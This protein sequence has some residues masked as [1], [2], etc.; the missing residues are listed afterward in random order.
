MPSKKL[1]GIKMSTIVWIALGVLA[2]S[3]IVYSSAK[4]SKVDFYTVKQVDV[5]YT[6]LA[7]CSVEYPDPLDL[8][9][10]SEG[11]VKSIL[12]REGDTVVNGQAIL[13][14]DD[15]DEQQNLII[16]SNNLATSENKLKS[17]RETDLPKLKEQLTQNSLALDQAKKNLERIKSLEDIGGVSK[18]EI[19]SAQNN[20]D[21]L[22]AQYNQTKLTIDTYSSTGPL[23]DLSRQIIV[24]KAQFDLAK[25]RVDEKTIRAPYT[26]T[27]LKI[28]AQ[29]GQKLAPGTIAA[30][31]IEKKSWILTLNVDQKEL[32]FLKPDLPAAV[33]LDS[34]PDK[35]LKA[36]IVYICT[37]VD[38]QKGT[39]EVRLE[40]I[41]NAPFVKHG[42]T[43]SSEIYAD[44]YSK[45][46]AIPS[47]F[48]RNS[49]EGSFVW[50]Y[51]GKK[52]RKEIVTL[53]SVGERWKIADNISENTVLL[54][55]PVKANPGKLIPGKEAVLP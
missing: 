27:I 39:C 23:A 38:E 51:D 30:T 35:K 1:F 8:T 28:Q 52:A 12:V 7:N 54:D 49:P 3:F 4:K 53:R 37:S 19:D 25:K 2:V 46:I 41:E 47:R 10:P 45:A 32:P 9:A 16:S 33:A 40:I 21:T 6:V 43:G 42:M 15:F 55:A 14:L 36:K 50:I 5:N 34:Y 11:T 20:V 22:Q 18:A 44:K 31:I 29:I 26:G 17:A 48:V 13:K 24:N